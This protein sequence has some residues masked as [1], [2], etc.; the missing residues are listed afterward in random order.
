[1]RRKVDAGDT[2]SPEEVQS[3]VTRRPAERCHQMTHR[4]VVPA[5]CRNPVPGM[6]SAL[7][8]GLRFRGAERQEPGD[9]AERCHQMNHRAVVLAGC[10]DPVPGMVSALPFGPRVRGAERQEPGDTAERCHQRKRRAMSPE[11][12]RGGVSPDAKVFVGTMARHSARQPGADNERK[13]STRP[14]R[15][16]SKTAESGAGRWRRRDPGAGGRAL[17]ALSECPLRGHLHTPGAGR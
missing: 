13:A 8:F 3:G 4:A 17:A 5:G 1:M 15:P 6:V 9:T 10:R 16:W 7:P 12:G 11:K 2:V 14:K